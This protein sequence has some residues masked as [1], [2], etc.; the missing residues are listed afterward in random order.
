M[1]S[2]EDHPAPQSGEREWSQPA[3]FSFNVLQLAKSILGPSMSFELTNRSA[4]IGGDD[5]SSC[6]PGEICWDEEGGWRTGSGGSGELIFGAALLTAG[7]GLLIYELLLK[8]AVEISWAS[9][10]APMPGGDHDLITLAESEGTPDTLTVSLTIAPTIFW[11]KA[12]EVYDLAGRMVGS[13]WC[14]QGEGVTFNSTTVQ[15][16]DLQGASFI[17]FK[18]AKTFGVHTSMYVVRNVPSKIGR[19]LAFTWAAQD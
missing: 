19:S 15:A 2:S 1:A 14:Q 3:R 4:R 12:V 10:G 6:D 5:P 11:W 7:T 8:G 18:K 9:F 16:V 13:A 17:V